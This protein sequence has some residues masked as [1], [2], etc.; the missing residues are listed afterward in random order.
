MWE[1]KFLQQQPVCK[2]PCPQIHLKGSSTVVVPAGF[3][4][5]DAGAT[6]RDH[7]GTDISADVY[8]EG[9]V[10]NVRT[11]FS[12]RG[13]CLGILHAA[14]ARGMELSDGLYYITTQPPA[15][16]AGAA[17][18][19]EEGTEEEEAASK[20]ELVWCDM[21]TRRRRSVGW[22]CEPAPPPPP[23]GVAG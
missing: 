12:D 11:A 17:G 21:R 5:R 19:T 8:T 13:S 7:T 20:K 15:L 9:N 14:R 18:A 6:A 23:P 1:I 2:L 10:V 3:P 16:P 22:K 4:Y